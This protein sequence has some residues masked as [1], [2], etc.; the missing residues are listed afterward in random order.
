MI[1]DRCRLRRSYILGSNVIDAGL[2]KRMFLAGVA[3][4]ES[5]KE[6]INEL[7]VFPVPDGDT[8]TNMTLTILSAARDVS[9]SDFIW[10]TARC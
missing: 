3:N 7:N 6:W 10:F 9:K 4:L 5:K 2:L 8:G 1:S